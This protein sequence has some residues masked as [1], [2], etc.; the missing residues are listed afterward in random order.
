MLRREPQR[1]E[2]IIVLHF[3]GRIKPYHICLQCMYIVFVYLHTMMVSSDFCLHYIFGLVIFVSTYIQIII[4]Q[5]DRFVAIFWSLHYPGF[6]TNSKAVLICCVSKIFSTA[7][8]VSVLF[9]DTEYL[10]CLKIFPLLITKTSNIILISCLQL[11]SSVVVGIVSSYLGFKMVKIKK[12]VPPTDIC[13]IHQERPQADQSQSRNNSKKPQSRVRRMN[14]QP[15][16][17]YSTEMKETSI[18]EREVEVKVENQ[19]QNIQS[20]STDS[21]SNPV[22]VMAKT[23]L[24]MNYMVILNCLFNT[25][26]YIMSIIYWD[27]D[28][29]KGECDVFL[30]FNKFMVPPRLLIIFGGF[31]IFFYK[32]RRSDNI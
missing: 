16:M 17:F 27:C 18:T 11:C 25:P 28:Y 5:V 19:N 15:N 23:A 10:K 31:F 20:T 2:Y 7:V 6:A 14:D 30:L 26:F 8:S 24:S 22:F 9:F 3:R 13:M 1:H 21:N 29:E 12:S 32:M 4:M